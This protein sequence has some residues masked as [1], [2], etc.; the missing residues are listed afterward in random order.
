[1]LRRLSLVILAAVWL[2]LALAPALAQADDSTG[3]QIA[4]STTQTQQAQAAQA[5]PFHGNHK[6]KVFHRPGCRYYNCKNC[7][8]IFKTRQA[9]IK[10]GFRPCKV[11]KP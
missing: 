1:M 9:A 7:I 10:A 11:C 8:V 4:A 5:K 2:S 6:T 3:V